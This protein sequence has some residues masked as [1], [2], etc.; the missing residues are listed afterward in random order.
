[1]LRKLANSQLKATALDWVTKLMQCEKK[2]IQCEKK[3]HFLCNRKGHDKRKGFSQE[4]TGRPEKKAPRERDMSTDSR[5]SD[6]TIQTRS[7]T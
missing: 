7:V 4:S 1:M 3:R 6:P 2:V 5:G